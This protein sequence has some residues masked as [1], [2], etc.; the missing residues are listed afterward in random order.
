MR[1]EFSQATRKAALKRADGRC[2]VDGDVGC[3]LP[4]PRGTRPEYHHKDAAYFGGSNDLDNCQ[5]LCPRCHRIETRK[6]QP[7]L[8]KSRSII[9]GNGNLKSKRGGFRGHRRFNGEIVWKD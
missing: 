9:K 5:V 6:Q 2:E 8:D 4:F 7:A 3:G 1:Q